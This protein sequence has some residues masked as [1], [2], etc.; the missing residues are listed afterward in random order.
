MKAF[1]LYSEALKASGFE[2]AEKVKAKPKLLADPELKPETA[3]SLIESYQ[4]RRVIKIPS[5]KKIVAIGDTH[6]PFVDSNALS[7]LYAVIEKTKPDVVVQVG[8]LADMLA[9]SRFPRSLNLMTPRTEI[10]LAKDQASEM[11]RKIRAIVP[12]ANL[13]QLLGNH[14]VRPMRQI[15]EKWPEGE[16]FV[17]D[18]FT[19]LYSFEGVK[20]IY[21]PTEEFW[22]GDIAFIHGYRTKLGDHAR[23]MNANVV[24][25]HTHRGGTVYFPVGNEQKWELNA[26]FLA[27]PFSA[28]LSYRAQKLHNWTVGCGLIDELGPRFIPFT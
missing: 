22:V 3:E 23:F 24:C 10:A 28:A 15:I 1:G 11:W 9:A 13:V 2:L 12:S 20:T 6:F 21:D 14:C 25:G 5:Y 27:D 8:D 26:G 4:R 16:D 7:M 17:K 19:T 18:S